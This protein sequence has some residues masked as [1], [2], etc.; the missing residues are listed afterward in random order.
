MGR[1]YLLLWKNAVKNL[2]LF[3][4]VNLSVNIC[5]ALRNFEEFSENLL[6]DWKVELRY[7]C[8]SA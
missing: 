7:R 5:P 3:F 1:K 2:K 4:R 8:E 6:F